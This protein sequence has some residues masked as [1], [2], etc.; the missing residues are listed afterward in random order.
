MPSFIDIVLRPT[1]ANAP[2]IAS[3]VR[4]YLMPSIKSVR[5]NFAECLRDLR[6]GYCLRSVA[7][8]R[9]T[10]IVDNKDNWRFILTS[11]SV[12]CKRVIT[13]EKKRTGEDLSAFYE[14]SFLS[15]KLLVL[16][17]VRG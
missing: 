6:S 16:G 5:K 9:I 15:G 10:V 8:D 12:F 7:D 1:P 3:L 13:W 17:E 2:V 14:M 11:T 4:E